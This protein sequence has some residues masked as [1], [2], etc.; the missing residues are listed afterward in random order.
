MTDFFKLKQPKMT[1]GKVIRAF[2]K[3]FGFTL[4]DIKTLTGIK[5]TNLSAIEQD[6]RPV[7]LGAALKLAAIFG[8]DPGNILFP[9]G[10]DI[11]DRPEYK[12]IHQSAFVLRER[13]LAHK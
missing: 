2:R 10:M 1:P 3:N 6:K 8:L 7:S 13:K 11:L 9:S 5:T 4:E 12:K